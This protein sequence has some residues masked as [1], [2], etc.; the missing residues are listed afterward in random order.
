MAR[1]YRKLAVLAKIETVE[2]TDAVP[3]G[4]ANAIQMNNVTITPLAGDQVSRDLLLPYL[5]QQ[6]VILTGTYATLSGQ[7]EIAGAGA[8][9]DVPGYGVLLRMC[10]LAE[11]VDP[12]T[13]VQ[14]DPI[15]GA[16]E[17]GTLYFNHDG[18]RHI[19]LGAKGNV[20]ANLTPKQIPHFT[21]TLTGLLG[22]IS[23]TALPSV[24]Y[25]AFQ[26][27]V[28]VNKAN[29]TLSL[30]GTAA[31]AESV[32]A[33]LGNQVEP[34]FLIGAESVQIVDRNPSGTCVVEARL[35]ATTNWFSRALART[36]G[37]LA[38]Q[39]GTVAGNI[40]KIDAPAVEIGRPS[41]GQTQKIINYSL[42]LMLCTD[43]GDDE[44]KITVK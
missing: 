1:F 12:D 43:A 21:F 8:A 24:D 40:V 31:V 6:G 3:T 10:G 35:L 26:V 30:H 7:V 42:P 37:A 11:T 38:A 20:S 14:Y 22:T 17:S 33:D 5:G 34:R 44:L 13:D 4:M 41:E 25:T 32:A 23:D 19:L 36:R 15:S 39:H 28:P 9:G 29:T 2:G 16:F 27:P 18:V